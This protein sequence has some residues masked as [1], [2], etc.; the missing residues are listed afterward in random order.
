[1][2][3]S[4]N[5]LT[6]VLVAGAAAVAIAAIPTTIV[7]PARPQ[8][9]GIVNTLM[10]GHDP[11]GSYCGDFC[12]SY[13]LYGYQPGASGSPTPPWSRVIHRRIAPTA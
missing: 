2:R 3:F 1:M 11:D 12:G 13:R 7:A 8:Q 9:P 6:P 5:Y 4:P 10:T